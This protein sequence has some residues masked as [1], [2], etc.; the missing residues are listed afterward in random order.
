MSDLGDGGLDGL[1]PS[2]EGAVILGAQCLDQAWAQSRSVISSASSCLCLMSAQ[3]GNG[4]DHPKN[5]AWP[6]AFVGQDGLDGRE[7]HR[8]GGH[9]VEAAP[10]LPQDLHAAG[11][12]D[13]PRR[14]P[15]SADRQPTKSGRPDPSSP[16]TSSSVDLDACQ[17]ARQCRP[18]AWHPR[19]PWPR[20]S[21]GRPRPIRPRLAPS[22]NIAFTASGREPPQGGIHD[23]GRHVTEHAAPSGEV[24]GEWIG[25]APLGRQRERFRTQVDGGA[26]VVNL[27]EVALTSCERGIVSVGTH[28]S[29]SDPGWAQDSAHARDAPHHR[30]HDAGQLRHHAIEVTESLIQACRPLWRAR[31]KST[32]SVLVAIGSS[33][34][35]SMATPLRRSVSDRRAEAES[36]NDGSDTSSMPTTVLQSRDGLGDARMPPSPRHC[37]P[38]P[39][40]LPSS[41]G[42]S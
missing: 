28:G 3:S 8:R 18:G 27:V 21:A 10:P 35:K 40:R 4:S 31:V 41:R 9:Q 12:A 36:D 15:L 32:A 23:V 38:G 2:L 14:R 42:W 17:T 24:E 34:A 13:R 6:V 25:P 30:F 20:P 1:H 5:L 16:S 26:D 7:P 37:R 19:S 11:P 33:V 22:S 39:R 29:S